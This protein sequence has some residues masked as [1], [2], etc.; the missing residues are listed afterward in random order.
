MKNGA[1]ALE[2]YLAREVDF[3]GLDANVLGSRC[4]IG[5]SQ[6]AGQKVGSRVRK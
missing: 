3:D 6:A 4:H 1:E 2:T 5:R